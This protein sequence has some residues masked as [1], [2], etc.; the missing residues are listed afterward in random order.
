MIP[1]LK[2]LYSFLDSK[3]RYRFIALLMMIFLT[4]IVELVGIGSL[5]PYIKIL[6][7]NKIIHQ[8]H[9]I[10][11]I[12]DI[13]HFSSNT[14]FLIF[15][16]VLIFITILF[17][18]YMSCANNYYQSKFTY[19]LSNR[20]SKYCLTSYMHMP[21]DQLINLNSS[22]L[23]KHLLVDVA[24]VAALFQALL[25][26]L[27]DIMLLVALL[28]IMIWIDPALIVCVIVGIGSLMWLV[29]RLTKNKIKNLAKSN[30]KCYRFAYQTATEALSSLKDT[31]IYNAENYFIQ[32][33][34]KW[35]YRLSDQSITFNLISNMPT[36]IMNV[37]GFG[38]LLIVLLYL[39]ITG[40][41]LLAILPTIALIAV[42]VQRLLP[43][44]GRITVSIATIRRYTPIVF[45]VK[46][47]LDNLRKF[48]KRKGPDT[49]TTNA[50]IIFQKNLSI[51]NIY[52]KYPD[53]DTYALE[54]ISLSIPKNTS[55]GIIGE[56]GA[57]KSTF[58]DVLLG[59]LR[60]EEGKI[61]VDDI[62]ISSHEDMAL[63]NII[64][65]VPQQ[66]FLIDGT[67][68]E[69]IAF[70]V[71]EEDFNKVDF[72]RAIQVAQL[73]ELIAQLPEG[74]D[75]K[76]GEK[77]VKLSGGQRQRIGIA[78]ALYRDPEILILDEATNALDSATEKEFNE[79]LMTLMKKKTVIIIAHRL[80]SIKFCDRLIQL[81][82]GKIIA[83]GTY[84]DLL[85]NS[86]S[87][88]HIYTINETVN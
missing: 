5:F 45:I 51:K 73:E 13:L 65:Y 32:K 39:V 84:D 14:H 76:I 10:R 59:L 9:I 31:K 47:V 25:T 67:I 53:C 12:Y 79:S 3:S 70:G 27:T 57:G 8:N 87:F 77:G 34:L 29:N 64:G 66:V 60:T 18:G 42:S 44:A 85:A 88:R 33:Y 7:D 58:V 6:G 4:A 43:S 23:S 56:S 80:S 75:T 50:N 74:I 36:N 61:Y 62:D 54:N 86:E 38:V 35:N 40:G 69:N 83:S 20:L 52:Y 78:R 17:K 22:V 48:H 2:V 15:I 72:T 41:S 82:K 71:L 19:K 1:T 81:E 68:K 63:S 55:I 30:E 46:E 24:G 37:M 49:K 26:M 21:Y 11:Y 16:G 28:S